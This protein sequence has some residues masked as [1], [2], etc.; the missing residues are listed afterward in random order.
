MGKAAQAKVR[1]AFALEAIAAQHEAYY[2]AQIQA[3]K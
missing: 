3:K 1:K 2:Q